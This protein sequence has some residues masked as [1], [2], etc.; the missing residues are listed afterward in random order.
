MRC[1]ACK[2]TGVALVLC[3]REWTCGR[4]L[5]FC[6]IAMARNELLAAFD[7]IFKACGGQQ[8]GLQGRILRQSGVRNTGR[9]MAWKCASIG[10]QLLMPRICTVRFA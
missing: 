1:I 9:R 7:G 8:F 2:S 4:V 5:I 3:C 10:W 6:G